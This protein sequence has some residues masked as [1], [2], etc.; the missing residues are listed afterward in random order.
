MIE[1]IDLASVRTDNKYR[2]MVITD[3]D[4][5]LLRSDRSA[6]EKSIRTLGILG[7]QN[8]LRVIATGRHLKSFFSTV[9]RD[10]PIDYII[11]S[12]GA[13]ILEMKTGA[14]IRAVSFDEAET[15]TVY[16]AFYG[17]GYDFM[18]HL[19]IPENHRFVFHRH[20]SENA[21]FEMRIKMYEAFS[22]ELKPLFS[23]LE[24][25]CQGLAIRPKT[26]PRDDLADTQALLSDYTIIRTTSPLDGE[27][28]WIEVFPHVVSKGKTSAWLADKLGIERKNVLAIGND[29]ND[30]DMLEWAGA[31][32]MVENA[33][34]ELKARF[35]IVPSNDSDG[36]SEAVD[37]FFPFIRAING[38]FGL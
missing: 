28:L 8:I 5:T 12:S 26:S 15:A 11:F 32:M 30:T 22:S 29:Y 9:A 2:G 27:S 38:D 3:L 37:I 6:G 21:D 31:G 1:T 36:F 13:G 19:P 34:P 4:G 20:T 10:F 14:L 24:R 25:S 16:D 23:G 17:L 35:T 18:L 7:E 33:K